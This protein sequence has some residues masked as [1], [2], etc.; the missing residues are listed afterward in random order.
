[1]KLVQKISTAS[2]TAG[3]Y[4]AL[5]APAFAQTLVNICPKDAVF[6]KLCTTTADFG[7]I[8]GQAIS[9]LLIV[10]VIIALIFL[11]WGGI[12]WITSG[13]DKTK[14]ESA[15]G[16]IIGAIVGL[17]IALGAYFILQVVLNLFGV[18]VTNFQ[19]PKIIQ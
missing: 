7:E 4:L 19:L 17:I 1:M 18:N 3:A 9:I 15:R 6:A 5:A 8:V 14:V 2:L 13:G 12:K 10:A 11:I 16:T